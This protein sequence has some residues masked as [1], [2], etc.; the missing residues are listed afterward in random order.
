MLHCNHGG[1]A[2]REISEEG[3]NRLVPSSTLRLKQ[4]Q[5]NRKAHAVCGVVISAVTLSQQQLLECWLAVSFSDVI[6]FRLGT[7]ITTSFA[8][9]GC[10]VG[11]VLA[12]FCW[13][14]REEGEH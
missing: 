8:R 3:D 14:F 12:C 9:V 11:V 1:C 6:N 4:F 5:L 10:R 7:V 13:V 2:G